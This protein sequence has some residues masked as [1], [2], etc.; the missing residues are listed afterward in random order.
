MITLRIN[1]GPPFN[2]VTKK[3]KETL[4]VKEDLKMKELISLLEEKYGA[5]FTANIWDKKNPGELHERISIIIN[6]R[7]FRGDNFLDRTFE[8]DGKI[9]FTHYFFGG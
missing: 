3:S 8:N 7:T 2:E 9:W 1:Y 4:E 5:E 6:G